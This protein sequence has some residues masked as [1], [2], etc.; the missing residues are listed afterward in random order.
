[1]ITEVAGT[2]FDYHDY[3]ARGDTL[4]LSVGGP[5]REPP[6]NAFE[7]PEG[8][9]VEYGESGELVAVELMNVR[10]TLER[11]GELTITWPEKHR[12]SSATLDPLLAAA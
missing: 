6:H 1:M 10:W 2:R 9:V 11:E 3:D 8:H 5:R 12:V 4:F 7:T